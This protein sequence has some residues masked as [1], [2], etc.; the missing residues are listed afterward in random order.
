MKCM[1]TL[2]SRSELCGKPFV[3][4]LQ[5][6]A[7]EKT[8]DPTSKRLADARK[9]GNIPKSQEINTVF[10]LL[11][12]FWTLNLLGSSIYKEICGFMAYV[13]AI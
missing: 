13:W 9:K 3:L 2:I 5:L 1:E 8:E 7:G 12:G 6:F 11:A 10:V 4:D